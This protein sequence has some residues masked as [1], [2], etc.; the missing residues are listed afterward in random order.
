[1]YFNGFFALGWPTIFWPCVIELAPAC[2]L[3]RQIHVFFLM[4]SFLAYEY[5]AIP[6][7]KGVSWTTFFY[8]RFRIYPHLIPVVIWT[9]DFVY[10]GWQY[11]TVFHRRMFCFI[12]HCNPD[13]TVTFGF[14]SLASNLLYRVHVCHSSSI[15][16]INNKLFENLFGVILQYLFNICTY[17]ISVSVQSLI[18]CTYEIM[19]S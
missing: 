12:H 10:D 18:L 5:T 17:T 16:Y 9:M 8:F 1:M 15:S 4:F 13:C 11:F 14:C 19:E 7:C 3:N 2:N 6:I